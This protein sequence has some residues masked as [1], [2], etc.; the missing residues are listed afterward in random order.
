MSEETMLPDWFKLIFALVGFFMA[1]L[2]LTA[3]FGRLNVNPCWSDVSKGLETL[4]T[5]TGSLK[6]VLD[7]EC[8]KSITITSS[9]SSCE[10]A[11]NDYSDEDLVRSC[12]KT[13]KAEGAESFI[14]AMPKEDKNFI[15]RMSTAIGNKNLLWIFQGK[16]QSYV[17][18]CTVTDVSIDDE[19]C[20]S[21]VQGEWRCKPTKDDKDQNKA[22]YE[23]KLQKSAEGMTCTLSKA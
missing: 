22:V 3:V 5:H 1:L 10:L 13:C 15:E 2:I 6:M 23:L 7:Y 16:P 11:C 18:S 20:R 21:V 14:V 9:P 12:A 17:L 4:K 19:R 8:V